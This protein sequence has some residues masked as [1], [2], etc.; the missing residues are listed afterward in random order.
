MESGRRSTASK[1]RRRG[2]QSPGDLDKAR[3]KKKIKSSDEVYS[4]KSKHVKSRSDRHKR[5]HTSGKH[6]KKHKIHHRH[7]K[8]THSSSSDSSDTDS[9]ST[10]SSSDSGTSS[11]DSE[12]EARL[13]AKHKRRKKASHAKDIKKKSRHKPREVSD[14]ATSSAVKPSSSKV[15]VPK[16]DTTVHTQSESLVI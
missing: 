4:S 3:Q 1:R 7:R 10:E 14:R 11:S 15:T 6:K 8:A 13:R 16:Q 2:E 5:R 12:E 9:D